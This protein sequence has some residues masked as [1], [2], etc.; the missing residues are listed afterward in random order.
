MISVE[1]DAAG[2]SKTCC[3]HS[4]TSDRR[5]NRFLS[6]AVVILTSDVGPVCNSL[7]VAARR[8]DLAPVASSMSRIGFRCG[9]VKLR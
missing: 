4:L 7:D 5:N 6:P 9:P 3:E 1:P 2:V 8:S